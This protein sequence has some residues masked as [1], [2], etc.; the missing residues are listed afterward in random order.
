MLVEATV[1][2]WRSDERRGNCAHN[3]FGVV[4]TITVWFRCIGTLTP[5]SPSRYRIDLA[6]VLDCLSELTQ[7]ELKDLDASLVE[8]VA[9]ELGVDVA[10]LN[11][12]I[13]DLTN[14]DA[15]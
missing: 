14:P 10:P 1:H 15:P 5:K 13:F 7:R 8:A 4:P 12:N 6:K 9:T 3:Q 11:S 2:W